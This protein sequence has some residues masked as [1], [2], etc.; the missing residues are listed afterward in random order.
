MAIGGAVVAASYEAQTNERRQLLASNY[1]RRID[2]AQAKLALAKA[3]LVE[4]Q[5]R[6]EI[7]V[8]PSDTTMEATLQVRQAET[9]LNIARL[10]LEEVQITGQDPLDTITAPL[11]KGRDFVLQRLEASLQVPMASLEVEKARLQRAQR[12]VDVGLAEEPEIMAARARIVELEMALQTLQ[13]QIDVRR[14]FIKGEYNAALADLQLMLAQ[15]EQKR[16]ALTSQ[17][18][19]AKRDASRVKTLYEKG[20]VTQIEVAKAQLRV[21]EL[22]TELSRVDV[23]LSLIQEQIKQR[24][25]K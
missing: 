20:L 7:G 24:R 12:R 5:R 10:Q 16:A 6:Y 25:G 4:V 11:V 9:E 17:L 15:T 21:L 23:E 13:R 8:A 18:D 3:A 14:R 22:T 19:L 1:E 2:L